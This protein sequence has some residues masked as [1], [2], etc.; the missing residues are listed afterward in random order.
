MFQDAH[1]YNHILVDH[2]G[3]DGVAAESPNKPYPFIAK[4]ICYTG[5]RFLFKEFNK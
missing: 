1:F 3:Y 2:G 5:K 4:P